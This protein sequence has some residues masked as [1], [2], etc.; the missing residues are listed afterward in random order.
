MISVKSDL[1]YYNGI[2]FKSFVEGVPDGV[3][4]GGQYD[5]LMDNMNR[6]SRAIGF[7]VYMDYL[8]KPS[9]LACWHK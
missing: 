9:T 5:K 6:N 7:A 2:I 1:N 4:S 3:L 8:G